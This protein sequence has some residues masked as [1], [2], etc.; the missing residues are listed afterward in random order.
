MLVSGM[1]TEISGGQQRIPVMSAPVWWVQFQLYADSKFP[2]I[3][4]S[5]VSHFFSGV[6][7]SL[8][9]TGRSC[10]LCEGAMQHS[11]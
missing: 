6:F 7:F 4:V 10:L 8:L 11:L 5:I 3:Q 2:S 1:N 9:S